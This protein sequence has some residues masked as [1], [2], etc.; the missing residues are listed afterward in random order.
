VRTRALLAVLAVA[1]GGRAAEG[2]T[3]DAR[4]ALQDVVQ[5]V[6][7]A[8]GVQHRSL[9]V[10]ALVLPEAC[11]RE[12]PRYATEGLSWS[13]LAAERIRLD[14]SLATDDRLL[15]TGLLL[16][17]GE[18][19]RVLAA[20]VHP[21]G[22]TAGEVQAISPAGAMKVPEGEERT[23]VGLAGPEVRHVATLAPDAE[24]LADLLRLERQIAGLVGPLEAG[25]FLDVRGGAHVVEEV[26]AGQKALEP[27]VGA[28]GGRIRGHVA[29]LGEE[30]VEVVWAGTASLYDACA[31]EAV[32]G[33]AAYAALWEEV[34]GRAGWPV[35]AIPWPQALERA[36][37]V[38]E[39]IAKAGVR[40]GGEEH[41]WLLRA[42][43][44]SRLGW[45]VLDG[46]EAPLLLEAWPLGDKGP[47]P[48]PPRTPRLPSSGDPP[49]DILGGAMTRM[50][51]ERYLKRLQ[52]IRRG[53]PPR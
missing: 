24:A 41:R 35:E 10:V 2:R 18:A 38:M 46:D 40:A 52:Q 5:G 13:G 6:Q 26:K 49:D 20:P 28:Y 36:S 37:A 48:T 25:G 27:L 23:F 31:R 50:F 14:G 3:R 8:R 15:P 4:T 22:G 47:F 21:P 53:R 19:E 29:F 34:F 12:G 30:A 33:L 43:G 16:G 32:G 39:T 51:L 17:A 9:V 44:A 45:L 11:G 42:K 7:V 1:L